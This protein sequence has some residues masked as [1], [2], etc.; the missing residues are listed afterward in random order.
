LRWHSYVTVK[1]KHCDL[2][3]EVYHKALVYVV[4]M[5]RFV[6]W[7]RPVKFYFTLYVV[8]PLVMK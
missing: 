8:S 1:G 7:F 2:C 5:D 4:I 6:S 3:I